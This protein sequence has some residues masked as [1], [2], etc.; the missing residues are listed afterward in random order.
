M[1]AT[2]IFHATSEG[3]C[4]RY[5]LAC[6]FLENMGIKHNIVPCGTEEYSAPAQRP[7]NSILENARLK[8]AGINLFTDWKE[9]LVAFVGV[10]KE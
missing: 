6:V 8:M 2:G 4:S 7:A 1:R 3:Y 9:E 5:E 10:M